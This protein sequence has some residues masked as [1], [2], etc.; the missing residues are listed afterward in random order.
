[1]TYNSI[2]YSEKE[3]VATIT[4]NR[5]DVYNAFNEEMLR[6]LQT[7]M[8]AVSGNDSIRCVVITGAGKAFCSGQDL[9]DFKKKKSTFKEALDQRYNPLILK[10]ANLQKPV[11]CAMN[12]VAAGAGLSLALACDYRIAV[13]SATLIEVFIN[14]GLVPDSGSTFFLPRII[15]YARAFE[16]CVTGEKLS[17]AESLKLGLV[18][19][20]VSGN[21][22]LLKATEITANQFASMPTKAIGM[23][24]SL[25]KSSFNSS[26]EEILSMESEFQQ[27]AGNTEDFK[28]GIASFLEKRKSAFKGK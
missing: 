21:S 7:A 20:V 3:G 12:G 10:I 19:K 14:V 6:E 1:M 9:K 18:N 25:L 11:I 15:G 2:L 8:D 5:P 23:I 24:K 28:E 26:L 13:E 22:L 4:L 16:M 17:A 27:I